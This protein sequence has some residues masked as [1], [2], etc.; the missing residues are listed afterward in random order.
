MATT[1]CAIRSATVGTCDSYCDPFHALCVLG[2]DGCGGLVGVA[3]PLGTVRFDCW[4]EVDP[5]AAARAAAGWQL[6]VFGPVVDDVVFDAESGGYLG[7]AVF[8]GLA[9]ARVDVG[10]L[11]AGVGGPVTAGMFDLGWEW[12]TPAVGGAAAGV[13]EAGGDPL[14]DGAGGHADVVG[15]LVWGAFTVAE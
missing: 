9:G 14:V 11:V 10:V 7:D 6:V 4:G 15:D 3:E 1:V 2:F 12:D 8:V 5:Q 13:Q